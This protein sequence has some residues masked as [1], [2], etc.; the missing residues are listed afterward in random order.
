M[1]QHAPGHLQT[2]DRSQDRVPQPGASCRSSV[3][4]T[5][6]LLAQPSGGGAAGVSG[7]AV[8]TKDAA[9]DASF[10]GPATPAACQPSHRKTSMAP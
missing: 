5:T 3:A 2:P 10:P 8:P 6:H 4:L 1:L 7:D 9:A